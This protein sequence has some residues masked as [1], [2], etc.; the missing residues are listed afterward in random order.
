MLQPLRKNLLGR[1]AT[2]DVNSPVAVG[3]PIQASNG[4]LPVIT[5]APFDLVGWIQQNWIIVLLIVAAGYFLFK[6]K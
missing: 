3:A 6:K 1:A 4:T 2:L 5:P